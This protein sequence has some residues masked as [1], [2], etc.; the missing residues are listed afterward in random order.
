MTITIHWAKGVA[1]TFDVSGNWT[2]PTTPS[3]STNAY[4]DATSTTTY[5]VTSNAA[6]TVNGLLLDS[7]AE[8][9]ISIGAF[10]INAFEDNVGG[11]IQV[12]SG[13][14]LNVGESGTPDFR[15][16]NTGVLD[17]DGASSTNAVFKISSPTVLF[18]GGGKVT[19]AGSHSEIIA[20]AAP[21]T[22]INLDNTISGGG[23]IGSAHMT[24][25]NANAGTIDANGS[26]A[27]KLNTGATN[28]ILNDGLIESTSTG[29]L[30]IDS[31]M[32]ED[33]RLFADGTGAVTIA[34]NADV[35]GGGDIK[36]EVSGSKFVLDNGALSNGGIL[37]TVAGS[38]IRTVAGT[39]DTLSGSDIEN[40]GVISVANNSTLMMNATVVNSGA[41][42]LLST[43]NATKLEFYSTGITF[44][45]AGRIVLSDNADNEIVSNGDDQTLVNNGNTISAAGTIGDAHLQIDNHPGG[46][47]DANATVGM[48]LTADTPTPTL[49]F[50]LQPRTD[51]DH[52]IR[53]FDDDRRLGQRR[54]YRGGRRGNF[55]PRQLQ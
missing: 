15:F 42:E 53:R 22:L 20:G 54:V 17:I 21:A 26:L 49:D 11:D 30:V 43:G 4:I 7:S 41:L 19:L 10:T 16:Q 1:G 52:R 18:Q 14:T 37:S 29:G 36:A 40:A 23:T 12:D 51:P 13:A 47:I 39:T 5:L 50:G 24:L 55:A 6:I 34:D 3:A 45:G 35:S 25:Q 9:E 28:T 31:S 2:P 44:D 38:A 32:Y 8:L 48:I 33:G 27:L 46:V